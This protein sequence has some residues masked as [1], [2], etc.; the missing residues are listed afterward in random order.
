MNLLVKIN[1][2]NSVSIVQ[3]ETL[4]SKVLQETLCGPLCL[5]LANGMIQEEF[6]IVCMARVLMAG[7]FLFYA[8]GHHEIY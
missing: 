2:G 4:W 3:Y 5:S 7:A 1:N 6:H 8:G